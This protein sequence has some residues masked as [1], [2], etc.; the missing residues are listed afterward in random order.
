[1]KHAF[2]LC[3]TWLLALPSFGKTLP[4]FDTKD[5]SPYW[6][7]E[8]NSDTTRA[9][10]KIP[11]LQ[12]TD[13]DGNPVTE[14]NF[15]GKISV[16]NFFFSQCGT[17]CPVMMESLHRFQSETKKRGLASK[18]R[19][20]SFSITPDQDTPAT[21]KAYAQEHGLGLSNWSLLTG[22][23][24]QIY[25]LGRN[26]FKADRSVGPQKS[27]QNF[28]H[29]NYVYLVDSQRKLRGI[30]QST[31]PKQMKLLASDISTLQK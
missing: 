31:D 22:Q 16:V 6:P 7:G 30:Y 17:T 25:E 27:Q 23:R 12:F 15:D 8:A 10:T 28:T 2:L 1:M 13:Q 29:S 21:L 19:F 4:F 11:T 9:P 24:S 3:C 14:K 26:V 5:L 20:F 18:I